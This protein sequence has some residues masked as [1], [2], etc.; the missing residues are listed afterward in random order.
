MMNKILDKILNSKVK[1][2]KDLTLIEKKHIS[3]KE[4]NNFIKQMKY[5]QSKSVI[6]PL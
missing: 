4:F 2:Y 3:K 6:M 5:T 1:S